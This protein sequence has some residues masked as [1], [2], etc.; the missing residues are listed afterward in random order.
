[1][2]N[3]Y[4]LIASLPMLRKDQSEYISH[5]D[6]LALCKE[7]VSASDYAV[8]SQAT[9]TGDEVKGNLFIKGF[10]HYRSL[11]QKELAAQRSARL[12]LNDPRY[13]NNGEKESKITEVIHKA[14]SSDNPL[15]GEKLILSLYWDY[16][17][18]HVGLGHV[19]DL[20]FLLSYALRLQIL[21]RISSF[22]R[23]KGNAEFSRLFSNL[24]SEIFPLR[25]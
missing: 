3:Y 8:L 12:K 6:F 7:Q 19:F 20:T 9:L 18:S 23:E 25:G 11:V 5:E 14:V 10:S 4:Y 17:E 16:L 15:E 2:A 13:I 22:T 21:S 1:M 24:K